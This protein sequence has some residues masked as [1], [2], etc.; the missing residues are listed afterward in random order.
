MVVSSINVTRPSY[1]LYQ[2]VIVIGEN[3]VVACRSIHCFTRQAHAQTEVMAIARQTGF[4]TIFARLL[5]DVFLR[6]LVSFRIIT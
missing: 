4:M 2:S 3:S 6:N 5:D 1:K